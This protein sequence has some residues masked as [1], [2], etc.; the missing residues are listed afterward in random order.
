MLYIFRISKTSK[1]TSNFA[2]IGFFEFSKI[3]TN[4]FF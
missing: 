4:M 3:R 2:L 1:I